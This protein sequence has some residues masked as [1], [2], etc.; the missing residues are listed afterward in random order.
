V[1][2]TDL[3]MAPLSLLLLPL[4]SVTT[5]AQS[6]RIQDLVTKLRSAPGH[7][8][9]SP[10]YTSQRKFEVIG[11]GELPLQSSGPVIA[12]EK[13]AEGFYGFE[14]NERKDNFQLPF[15]DLAP[16]LNVQLTET[17]DKN[18]RDGDSRDPLESQ[19][20]HRISRP[21]GP[22]PYKVRQQQQRLGL[23]PLSQAISQFI[24]PNRNGPPQPGRGKAGNPKRKVPSNDRHGLDQERVA[25]FHPMSDKFHHRN[26]MKPA[27]GQPRPKRRP[28]QKRPPPGFSLSNPFKELLDRSPLK[29]KQR[30]SK[31]GHFRP[32]S[33]IFNGFA[34]SFKGSLSLDEARR[35]YEKEKFENDHYQHQPGR[36][37]GRVPPS[38]DDHKPKKHP[39]K[40]AGDKPRKKRR[41]K[42]S[43]GK[44]KRPIQDDFKMTNDRDS[45]KH[46]EEES[47]NR[48][49]HDSQHKPSLLSD[50]PLRAPG[51]RPK[52]ENLSP[53]GEDVSSFGP[54]SGE[55]QGV[56]P[57]RQRPRPS[58]SDQ[59]DSEKSM[60]NGLPEEDLGFFKEVSFPD[61]GEFGLGWD[62]Q[63]VRRK[64]EARE[65]P[66]YY[67]Q[68]QRR[69]QAPRRQRQHG[70][71]QFSR[72]PPASHSNR[73]K[74][75]GGFWDD[76]DFDADFFSGT[77]PQS[78]TNFDSYTNNKYQQQQ[79][80][81]QQQ[82]YYPQQQSRPQ[83]PE[84]PRAYRPRPQPK[85]QRPKIKPTRYVDRYSISENSF[86]SLEQDNS[87]L[88]S[89]NFDILKGGTF[90]E[91]GDYL[92]PYSNIRPQKQSSYYGGGNDI[93]SNFRDFAD[94]K[95]DGGKK[96]YNSYDEGYY[97]R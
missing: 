43:A 80:R 24:R 82:S 74:G 89:G 36:D 57:K 35:Q 37:G 88:G 58:Y 92:R 5:H 45:D 54:E 51:R 83:Y 85:P 19:G 71:R 2:P 17:E 52:P 29:Y 10:S 27:P 33:K 90:Y 47:F 97:Y 7:Q 13:E 62:P 12:E 77:G 50:E 59:Y 64:R 86:N 4:L 32:P 95:K 68:Q 72:P 39:G 56:R 18:Y 55:P 84:T 79:P 30:P 9:H 44:G 11:S 96:D 73:R 48:F 60:N 87:I 67:E 15:L 76:P 53:F 41:R 94:I 25:E 93:F 42:P 66:Y 8:S 34:P 70:Q 61:I 28:P 49:A 6:S 46:L 14:D 81:P 1:L 63:K 40:H 20:S 38:F 69:P 75:P 22:S 31:G 3:A 26:Q 78:L 91:K 21:S 23:R 16:T 65:F